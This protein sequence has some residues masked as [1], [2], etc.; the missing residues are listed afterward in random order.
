[1]TGPRPEDTRLS[2]APLAAGMVEEERLAAPVLRFCW[3]FGLALLLTTHELLVRQPG[4]YLGP[5]ES[6]G[7]ARL[8]SLLAAGCAGWFVSLGSSPERTLSIHVTGLAALTTVSGAA[9]WFGF[10]NPLFFFVVTTAMP[11]LAAGLC[12]GAAVSFVRCLRDAD[13]GLLQR[14]VQPHVLASFLGAA[15]VA[16]ALASRL[17]LLHWSLALGAFTAFLGTRT[18]ATLRYL[19]GPEPRGTGFRTLVATGLTAGAAIGLLT[20]DRLVTP[21]EVARAPGTIVFAAG[22]KPDRV[23]VTSAQNAFSVFVDGALKWSGLDGP[24]YFEAL[25]RPALAVAE[26]PKRALVLGTGE[27]VLARTLLEYPSVESVTVVTAEGTLARLGEHFPVFANAGVVTE[28]TFASER[29]AVFEAEP[30]VWL[31][32]AEPSSFDVVLVDLADPIDPITAKNY[33]RLFF[34]RVR[35]V[36]N[37]SGVLA[38]QALSA[39]GTRKAFSNVLSTVQSAGFS[40]AAYDV[41]LV[42]LGEWGYVLGVPRNGPLASELPRRAR[43]ALGSL[44]EPGRLVELEESEPSRLYDLRVLRALE[45]EAAESR[46]ER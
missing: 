16:L 42:S 46:Q 25:T 27:G 17:G 1:M 15:V 34:E 40:A 6:L 21:E 18:D 41:E 24:R 28:N 39:S 38:V 29:L 10:Q 35:E 36:M 43:A 37:P 30:I 2:M 13:L 44:R 11:P 32:D 9:W 45:R 3:L 4:A 20:S 26:S 7:L 33:T 22:S 19:R 31:A 5:T 23:V 8:T 14:A 12:S